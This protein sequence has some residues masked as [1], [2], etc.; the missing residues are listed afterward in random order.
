MYIF[1]SEEKDKDTSLTME[2]SAS[3]LSEVLDDFKDFLRG[4]GFTVNGELVIINEG[5][6]ML[7]VEDSPEL[8]EEDY[9]EEKERE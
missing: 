5:T 2:S 3:S 4:C 1:K 7:I 9:S 8:L 6:S